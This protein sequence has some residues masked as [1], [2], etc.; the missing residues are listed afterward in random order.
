MCVVLNVLCIIK[1]LQ[2]N[3]QR[4]KYL[5]PVCIPLLFQKGVGTTISVSVGVGNSHQKLGIAKHPSADYWQTSMD[6][7]NEQGSSRNF[8]RTNGHI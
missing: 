7:G 2:K 8:I 6:K 4:F 5:S 3:F 1:S